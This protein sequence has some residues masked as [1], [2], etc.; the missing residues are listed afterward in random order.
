VL[1]QRS[2]KQGLR[3]ATGAAN[4][5]Q[6]GFTMEKVRD[7]QQLYAG[8]RSFFQSMKHM[9]EEHHEG[10]DSSGRP[11]DYSYESKRVFMYSGCRDDQ[12]SADASIAGGHV[13]AMSWAFLEVMKQNYGHLSYIDILRYTR[14]NL[15]RSYS[16]VP[17]LSSGQQIDLNQPFRI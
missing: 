16:Q 12:T 7:A 13:G 1:T 14:G 5:L 6:G 4:L 2:L 10:L 15:Q 3:L 11:V 8:A 9:G 17:Q